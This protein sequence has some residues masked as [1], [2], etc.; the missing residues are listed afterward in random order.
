MVPLNG[1]APATLAHFM[2]GRVRIRLEKKCRDRECV[3]QITRQLESVPGIRAVEPHMMTGSIVVR[4]DP[5]ILDPSTLM[6]IGQA[7]NLIA[8]DGGLPELAPARKRSQPAS[9]QEGVSWHVLIP[10][11]LVAYSLRQALVQGKRPAAPWYALLWYA[12]SIY[13]QGQ[14]SSGPGKE[15]AREDAALAG[16]TVEVMV[17]AD[18]AE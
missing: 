4:Y 5:K 18:V 1:T 17:A 2:P 16:R 7:M 11:A 3:E 9:P 13:R 12:Y 14:S 6:E 8:C 10:V 15:D